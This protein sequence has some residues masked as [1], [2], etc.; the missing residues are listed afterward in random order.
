MQDDQGYVQRLRWRHWLG[1]WFEQF[2]RGVTWSAL[3]ILAL[4]LFTVIWQSWGWVTWKFLTQYDSSQ[5]Q[6]AGVWA[7]LMGSIW[8]MLLTAIFCIPL[9]VGAAIYLEEYAPSHPLTRIIQLNV[10]NLAGVPSIVYGM[11]GFTVFVRMFGLPR[12][13]YELV[14]GGTVIRFSLPLGR[15]LLSGALTLTLLSL[16]VVIIATQEAL[17]AV[18]ASLRHASYAL[19]ATKWQTIWRQ[20]LP[21]AMP[22]ILTG[23]ILALSRAVGETAPLAV[24]GAATYITFVPGRINHWSDLWQRPY[25]LLQAPFDAFTALPLQIYN[26]VNESNPQFQHVAAAA[27][28]VLLLLLLVMNGVAI[29]LRERF[30]SRMKW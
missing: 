26:W 8:L 23:V 30:R 13:L 9:G 2:C 6:Q 20:V 12:E 22:G 3:L 15:V 28:V 7:G 27:I 17:R 14:V 5:P 21:A 19:G 16:P 24:L 11:L 18:P 25:G 10:A 4:L 1:W 29:I